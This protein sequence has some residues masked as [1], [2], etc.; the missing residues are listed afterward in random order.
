[1]PVMNSVGAKIAGVRQSRNLSQAE[2]AERSQQP[3]GL[4]AEIESGA[5][6][7]SLAPLIKIARA[8]GVRLGTFLDDVEHIGPVVCRKG[9]HARV[10]R[11][12]GPSKAASGELD[13]YS[14]SLD[15]SGRHMDP[16]LIEVQP[17]LDADVSLSSHEGEEFI[18]VLSG[19]IEVSYGKEIHRLGEGDSIYYD[20]IVLHSVRAL[21]DETARVLAV[22]YAPF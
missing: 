16:F 15:K 14:L 1:M 11:F 22:I 6:I 7:P 9:Q 12:S 13:F 3:E 19:R 17:S 2:L 10:V 4:I 18:Y 20:S 5:L 8:L 21:G